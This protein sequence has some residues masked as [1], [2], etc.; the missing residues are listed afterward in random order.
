MTKLG[1]DIYFLEIRSKGN[2]VRLFSLI[3]AI[4]RHLEKLCLGLSSALAGSTVYQGILFIDEG[5][6]CPPRMGFWS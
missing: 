2:I 6:N 5:F 3:G 4:Y 1:R